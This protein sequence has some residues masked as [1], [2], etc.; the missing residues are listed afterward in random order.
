VKNWKGLAVVGALMLGAVVSSLPVAVEGGPIPMPPYGQLKKVCAEAEN[1][2]ACQ[3]SMRGLHAALTG[4]LED[5]STGVFFD[6]VVSEMKK[7]LGLRGK[8]SCS[9]C[10]NTV[11]T[12]QSELANNSTIQSIE[13]LGHLACEEA[14]ADPTEADE[15]AEF[16][17]PA[18]IQTIQAIAG[19]MTPGEVCEAVNLCH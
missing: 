18:L 10:L 17:G 19:E 11:H 7:V 4:G 13:E 16:I 8:M 2:A 14:Y 3:V 12:F 5:N 9:T 6:N 15:C 1:P